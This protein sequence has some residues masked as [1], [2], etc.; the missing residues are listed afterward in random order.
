MAD[1]VLKQAR[2]RYGRWALKTL[3]ESAEH[4][5]TCPRCERLFLVAYEASAEQLGGIDPDSPKMITISSTDV[6]LITKELLHE[7]RQ[8]E[9]WP[10]EV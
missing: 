9:G 7:F 8:C 3:S 1:D 4:I 5:R 10:T 2:Y 6:W